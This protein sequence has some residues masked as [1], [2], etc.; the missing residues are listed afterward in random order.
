MSYNVFKIFNLQKVK[1]S[2]EKVHKF[3]LNLR[4]V[5]LYLSQPTPYIQMEEGRKQTIVF[6]WRKYHTIHLI[7]SGIAG[8]PFI[9]GRVDNPN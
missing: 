3:W 6:K 2:K 7:W 8:W 9:L 5:K 4:I 1:V